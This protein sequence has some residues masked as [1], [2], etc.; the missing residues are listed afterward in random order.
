MDGRVS[1]G[2]W[3][4][5]LKLQKYKVPLDEQSCSMLPLCCQPVSVAIR[6]ASELHSTFCAFKLALRTLIV[7]IASFVYSRLPESIVEVDD[8]VVQLLRFFCV[9]QPLRARKQPP[10]PW[11]DEHSQAFIFLNP[12]KQSIQMEAAF[13][14]SSRLLLPG[15]LRW[16]S[17]W[18]LL[19]YVLNLRRKL[20]RYDHV[21]GG[22]AM[23][24]WTARICSGEF[25]LGAFF[26]L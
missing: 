14:P 12:R 10:Q 22:V 20:S 4:F 11:G 18:N 26:F 16:K 23:F 17:S 3:T 21:Y 2:T 9:V 1:S 5:F 13:L 24:Q 8:I 25:L 15:G 19:R 6:N 7:S